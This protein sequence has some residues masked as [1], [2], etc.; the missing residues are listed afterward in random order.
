MI[1]IWTM[2]PIFQYH[3]DEKGVLFRQTSCLL[4]KFFKI[5]NQITDINGVFCNIVLSDRSFGGIHADQ[6]NE[7]ITSPIDDRNNFKWFILPDRTVE[8]DTTILVLREKMSNIY[9]LIIY[10]KSKLPQFYK[11]NI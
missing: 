6:V 10:L 11:N 5:K 3:Q 8:N 7:I 2:T 1:S 9:K 4:E